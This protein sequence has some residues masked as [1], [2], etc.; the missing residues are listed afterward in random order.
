MMS[1]TTLK[2]TQNDFIVDHLRGTGR[3]LT[4]ALAASNYGI[5][6]LRARI[7]ELR[8]EGYK[9]RTRKNTVGTTSYAISRRMVGQA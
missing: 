8:S 4:S 7:S 2:T 9:V 6:N 1:F 5:K 3:E